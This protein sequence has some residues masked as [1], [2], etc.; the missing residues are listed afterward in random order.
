[1]EEKYE[2]LKGAES[3]YF[4]GNRTGILVIH[5]FTG[6]TESM[7]FLGDEYAK[8]GY[9]VCGPRLKGHGTHYKDLEQSVYHEWINSVEEGLGWL[10]GRCDRIFV[11][12]L[13][14]GG[15]L[16]LYLAEKYK[17][18]AGI[19]P[20]NA[21]VDIPAMETLSEGDEPQYLDSIGSDIKAEGI[22]ELSYGK[23]PVR[24]IIELLKLMKLVKEDLQSV[25]MPTLVFS[26]TE[27][28]VVP[29]LN[30][31]LIMTHISSEKKKKVDLPN[32]YHVATMDHDKEEIVHQSLAFIQ[33]LS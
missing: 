7:K 18:I 15:T 32:S 3:F 31:E 27:D 10:N 5:G 13:S 16:T 9:T 11:T 24:S 30:A 22:V 23:T 14:M 8:A 2:V 6:T 20:I 4:E 1:M 17:F 12:G 21:A 28:H 29:P 25:Y 19:M 33:A 26:S